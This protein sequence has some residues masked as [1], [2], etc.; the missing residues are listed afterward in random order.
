MLRAGSDSA[1]CV[2]L[3]WGFAAFDLRE[4]KGVVAE[5]ATHGREIERCMRQPI[6]PTPPVLVDIT[7]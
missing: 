1:G 2:V 5:D 6:R 4:L 3:D 7:I